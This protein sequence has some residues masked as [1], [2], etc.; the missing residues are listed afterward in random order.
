VV[1]AICVAFFVPVILIFWLYNL[2]AIFIG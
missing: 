1:V 2:S